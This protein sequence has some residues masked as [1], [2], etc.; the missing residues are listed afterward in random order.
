MYLQTYNPTDPFYTKK[1]FNTTCLYKNV[2][3]YNMSEKKGT[4]QA[5]KKYKQLAQHTGNRQHA[6][7]NLRR[8]KERVM[9]N[10]ITQ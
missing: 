1:R 4:H 2:Y 7:L 10:F 9:S 6:L 8:G 3:L 5:S